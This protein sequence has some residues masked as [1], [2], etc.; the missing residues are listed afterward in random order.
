MLYSGCNWE[1][2]NYIYFHYVD[3]ETI[4]RVVMI[5]NEGGPDLED[6]IKELNM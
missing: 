3:W 2:D 1:T 4:Q 6:E 5:T